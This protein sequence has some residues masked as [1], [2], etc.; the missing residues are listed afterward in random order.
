[1]A[2]VYEKDF[3]CTI[4]ELKR[5][6]GAIRPLRPTDFNCTIQE[7]KLVLSFIRLNRNRNFNCTIQELKLSCSVV[8]EEYALISIAPYRN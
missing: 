7:L 2:V 6:G 4:Q 8:S 3:N 5:N 1:M